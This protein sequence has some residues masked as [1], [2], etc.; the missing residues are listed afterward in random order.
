MENEEW[1]LNQR[2][3]IKTS[4]DEEIE[5]DI[6]SYDTTTG[7]VILVHILFYDS[8]FWFNLVA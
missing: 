6:F 3:R 5:G 8:C 1:F 2:I 4:F 7:C